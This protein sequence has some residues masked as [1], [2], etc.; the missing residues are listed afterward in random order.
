MYEQRVSYQLGGASPSVELHHQVLPKLEQ[1]FDDV[2]LTTSPR[3]VSAQG[4]SPQDRTPLPH[5]GK[6]CPDLPKDRSP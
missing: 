2:Q 4:A 1:D 6:R 5:R 3:L